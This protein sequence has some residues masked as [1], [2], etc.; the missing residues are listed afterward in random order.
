MDTPSYIL[1]PRFEL[2]MGGAAFDDKPV[3]IVQGS[4]VPGFLSQLDPSDDIALVTHN[5]QFDASILSWRYNWRPKLIVDTLSMSR[6]VLANKIPGHSLK[7]VANYLKL[8]EKGMTIESVKGMTRADIIANGMM[9]DFEDYCR[10]DVELCRDIFYKLASKM[11]LEE[12]A[13]HDLVLRMAVD[14][15]LHADVTVLAEY[16]EEVRRRRAETLAHIMVVAV[17]GESDLMSNDKLAKVLEGFGVNPPKK[18][19]PAT[20]RL[21]WA[22]AK[23]DGAFQDLRE[24]HNPRVRD[25]V[26]ARLKYKS[27]IEETRAKRLLNIGS[28]SFPHHGEHMLPV[29]LRIGGAR[30]H[31]FSGDWKCNFQNLGRE[32][33]IRSAVVAPPGH[34]LVAADAAQIEARILAWYC[35]QEDLLEQF[36]QGIDVYAAFASRLFGYPVTRETHKRERFLG[37]TGVL[38]CGYQCGPDKFMA[39]VASLSGGAIVLTLAEAQ[40]VVEGYREINHRI[41]WKWGWL[42]KTVIPFMASPL[43]KESVIKDGPVTFGYNEVTGPSNLKMFYPSL[44]KKHPDGW[45]YQDGDKPNKLYGGKLTENIVQH[46]ARVFIM[47]VALRLRQCAEEMNIR[48]A[49]QSHDELVYCVPNEHVEVLT[50]LLHREMTTPSDW[51][52]GL[53][54]A[55]DVKVGP[56][57]GN[58]EKV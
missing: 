14:P 3:E 53:P 9:P 50:K 27:T 18:V 58:M 46:M 5:A 36:R 32:S 20:G 55:T 30:T 33:T 51:C 52:A 25:V 6:T 39:M 28:L 40:Q 47:Q 1:D 2:I 44:S 48:L 37:K 43:A 12:F 31:R 24:H 4:D 13:V 8:P 29:A 38:G 42:G 19:S 15:V 41:E 11:P 26:E 49:L 17:E 10:T 34:T 23:T 35:G 21:T 7:M 57:Y 45:L 22:F 16:A 56:N 54:L